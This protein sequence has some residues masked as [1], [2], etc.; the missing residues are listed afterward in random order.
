MTFV[1]AVGEPAMMPAMCVPWPKPSA[2]VVSPVAK[3]MEYET[4]PASA[5]CEVA[6]P[7][8]ITATPTPLPVTAGYPP[9]PKKPGLRGA[10]LVGGH[11]LGRHRHERRHERIARDAEHAVDEAKRPQLGRRGFDHDQPV[12]DLHD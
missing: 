11:R 8:S 9:I 7:E 10:R 6:M 5:A 3:L 1:A 12:E 2:V 4:L